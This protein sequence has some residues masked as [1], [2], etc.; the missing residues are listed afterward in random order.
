M[1]STNKKCFLVHDNLNIW[2]VIL[3]GPI[4]QNGINYSSG[5]WV[6]HI[7]FTKKFPMKAPKIHFVNKIYHCNI[8][9][10]GSICHQILSTH[11][12]P[13][14]TIKKV[15]EAIDDLLIVPNPTD[16]LDSIKAAIYNDNLGLYIEN[17]HK[18]IAKYANKNEQ[19]LRVEY[20]LEDN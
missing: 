3:P 11:W 1:L 4:G 6:L 12:A 17:I 16:A 19:Q 8:N 9:E 7:K 13:S 20:K 14:T 5:T 18:Y 2:K 15:F 10:D